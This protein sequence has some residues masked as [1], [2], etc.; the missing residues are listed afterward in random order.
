MKKNLKNVT[1]IGLDCVDIDRLKLAADICQED[2]AFG[3][4]KLLTS[5]DDADERIVN[6]A[7]V[8]ST[9]EYSKIFFY[10]LLD[11]VDTDFALVIQHDGFIL[12][13]AAWTDEFFKYDYIG[14][15]WW[16]EDDNNVGN[17]GFSL[18]SKK[19]LQILKSD[20]NLTQYHGEDHCICRVYGDY[21]K[22]KGI[23][24]VPEKLASTF[25]IEGALLPPSMPVK[26]GSVWKNEFGFHGIEKTDI[27]RWLSARPEYRVIG[28]S[29]Q[30][31]IQ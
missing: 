19:L 23:R 29:L 3:A 21:L 5:I 1:L 27:S 17:G 20:K 26:Y 11:Y 28:N 4:V 12:N 13:P 25:S 22:T 2:F 14:A 10:D 30:I 18:R 6:I 9:E 16:Y 31:R 8:T 7:P 24:F 15:P